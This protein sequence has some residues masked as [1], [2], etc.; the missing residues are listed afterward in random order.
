MIIQLIKQIRY[1]L[2][3]DSIDLPRPSDTTLDTLS[4]LEGW[5]LKVFLIILSSDCN[6]TSALNNSS[7]T[8]FLVI[9]PHA[10]WRI[11][12]NDRNIIITL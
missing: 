10:I 11:P 3:Y 7:V 4:K 5:T 1:N 6:P 2:I 12:H 8:I 9:P